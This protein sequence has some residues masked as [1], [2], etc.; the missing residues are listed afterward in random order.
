MWMELCPSDGDTDLLEASWI[1]EGIIVVPGNNNKIDVDNS[2]L[3]QITEWKNGSLLSTDDVVITGIKVNEENE[4][5]RES[6]SLCGTG[7]YALE[8]SGNK[9]VQGNG[10]TVALYLGEKINGFTF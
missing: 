10:E 7:E 9:L 1:K 3:I 4:G 5:G 8:I 2:R 6:S